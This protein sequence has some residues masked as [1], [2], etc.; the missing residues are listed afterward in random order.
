MPR[1][2]PFLG[3]YDPT[4]KLADLHVHSSRSDGTLSPLR[5]LHLA[6]RRRLSG[7]VI[8]DHDDVAPGHEARE[9]SERHGL[10]LEVIPCV[11]ITTRTA[12]LLAFDLPDDVP[13][14]MSVGRTIEA[15]VRLGGWVGIPHPGSGLTPSVPFAEVL[16]IAR[17]GLPVAVEVFNASVRDFRLV[18]RWRGLPD[19]N[20]AARAFYD[21]HRA[22]L[23][24]ALAGTDAHYRTVGRAAVAYH[25]DLRSALARRATSVVFTTEWE[26]LYPWDLPI[27]W[28]R[29]R[30]LDAR[31]RAQIAALTRG[32]HDE[33]P[34]PH[35]SPHLA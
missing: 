35:P 13:A 34:T 10:G 18:A 19:S 26:R 20:L 12:H 9:L 31:R 24:P 21:E 25:G 27:H 28:D 32:D 7:L 17:A 16:A 29:L 22:I 23:G 33:H 15:I 1:R 11:E 4:M 6:R 14:G 2:Y 3:P 30:R 5:L 8:T